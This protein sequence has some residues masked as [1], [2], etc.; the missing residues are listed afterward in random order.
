MTGSSVHNLTTFLYVL[1][2]SAKEKAS[3]S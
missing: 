2:I 1:K 3:L